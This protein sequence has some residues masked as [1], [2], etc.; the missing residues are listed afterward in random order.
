MGTA[1]RA[2]ILSVTA[3]SRLAL[4]AAPPPDLSSGS[5]GWWSL[6]A[7][8]NLAPAPP[9]ARAA[10]QGAF[11]VQLSPPV[12]SLGKSV[13]G[14]L[15]PHAAR[16]GARVRLGASP[17]MRDDEVRPQQ[18]HHFFAS[19]S[20]MNLKG[21]AGPAR[22]GRGGGRGGRGGE[23]GGRGGE[24]EV[25]PSMIVDPEGD[26]FAYSKIREQF[27]QDGVKPSE[28][29]PRFGRSRPIESES[30]RERERQIER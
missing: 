9:R 14:W 23:R 13:R 17:G 16:A 30:E 1:A 11:C 2:I 4:S 22:G 6:R 15:T 24:E 8:G 18:P 10:A 25:K 12:G 5:G 19:G 27:K 29:G 3:S 21:G 20:P 28:N 26:L 7:T